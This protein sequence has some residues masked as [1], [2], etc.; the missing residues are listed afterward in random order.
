MPG[1]THNLIRTSIA[2][3]SIDG[4]FVTVR[5]HVGRILD[6]DVESAQEIINAS[7]Q[8]SKG[9]ARLILWDTREVE[10]MVSADARD[11]FATSDLAIQY[12]KALAFVVDSL[13]IRLSAKFFIN[14]NAPSSPSAIFESIDEAK[15]WLLSQK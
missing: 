4:E 5:P 11:I 6:L 9:K 8:L 13:A 1:S 2:D 3:V 10:I 15:A 7:Y 14:V 12:R